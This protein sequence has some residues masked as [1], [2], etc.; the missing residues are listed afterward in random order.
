MVHC[1]CKG[2]KEEEGKDGE[3][4]FCADF[5]GKLPWDQLAT[6]LHFRIIAGRHFRMIS[7]GVVRNLI[8][9]KSHPFPG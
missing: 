4:G 5:S 9:S 6:C 3:A 8:L 2:R 1:A 7:T